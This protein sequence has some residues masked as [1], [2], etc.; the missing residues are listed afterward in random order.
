MLLRVAAECAVRA[1]HDVIG[2]VDE[3]DDQPMQTR[4]VEQLVSV[5]MLDAESAAQRLR[6]AAADL[7]L[8]AGEAVGNMGNMTRAMRQWEMQYT[9]RP[10]VFTGLTPPDPESAEYGPEEFDFENEQRW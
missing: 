9:N 2:R 7:G 3:L 5:N 8:S 4:T 6:D 10:G 1:L